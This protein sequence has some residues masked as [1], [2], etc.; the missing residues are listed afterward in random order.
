VGLIDGPATSTF[1]M[2]NANATRNAY[3][4]VEYKINDG[5]WIEKDT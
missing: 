4:F 3:F 2:Q 5:D 1:T